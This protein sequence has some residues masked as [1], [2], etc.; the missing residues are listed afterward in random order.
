MQE[1]YRAC[2]N[3]ELISSALFTVLQEMGS[4]EKSMVA[5]MLQPEDDEVVDEKREELIEWTANSLY[6][7]AVRLFLCVT[8][9]LTHTN[10]L[11]LIQ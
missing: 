5:I 11:D 6:A 2:D 7:G 10:Q 9:T 3:L 1:K 8:L 4:E